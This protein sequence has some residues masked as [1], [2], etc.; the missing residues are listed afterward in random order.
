MSRHGI[1]IG[2]IRLHSPVSAA[3]ASSRNEQNVGVERLGKYNG[4]DKQKWQNRQD[5]IFLDDLVATLEAHRDHNR[6][7]VIHKFEQNVD[8]AL[9][10]FK[11]LSLDGASS[12][13]AET[14]YERGGDETDTNGRSST[15]AAGP[16]P[17]EVSVRAYRRRQ[18]PRPL[19]WPANSVQYVEEGSKTRNTGFI[20]SLD[21]LEY[22]GAV[23]PIK[24]SWKWSGANPTMINTPWAPYMEDSTGD[25]YERSITVESRQELWLTRSRLS[26]EI[27]AFEAYMR[28]SPAEEAAAKLVHSDVTL[29][30]RKH[31][32]P[33]SL[34]L[35]GSRST[36]LAAPT[37][38]FDYRVEID[39]P[40]QASR[41]DSQGLTPKAAKRTTKSPLKRIL[42]GLQESKDIV[43]TEL[44]HVPVATVKCRHRAT[45]L[46]IQFRA[47]SP[48]K[49]S[50]Q[51]TAAY[52]SEFPSLRPLYI[53][54][55]H[56]LEIRDLTSVFL[57]GL[58][59]YTILMMIV[60][61]LKHSS[62]KFPPNDLGGQLLHI[63]DFYGNAD[64]Y[65]NGFSA[66]PPRT[67]KKIR[68]NKRT[69][70]E[71]EALYSDLQLQ[72]VEHLIENSNPRKPYLLCLQDPAHA[73]ND[74]GKH[75][76]AIK[77][78]Q[79][80]FKKMHISL[81]VAL[82]LAQST[83]KYEDW[84]FL[85]PMVRADYSLFEIDRRNIERCNKPDVKLTRKDATED[86][87]SALLERRLKIY[88]SEMDEDDLPFTP[89][90]SDLEP[91]LITKYKVEGWYPYEFRIKPHVETK[92]DRGQTNLKAT[93]RRE[94]REKKKR[95]GGAGAEKDDAAAKK[96]D[97]PG[98]EK[99][100]DAETEGTLLSNR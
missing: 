2:H 50:Q 22:T 30:L 39:S 49:A 40:E 55:R 66:D 97:A 29:I 42:R 71:R 77:H 24:K 96:E 31:L 10:P 100:N 65:E 16:S 14:T 57:G 84:S 76:Y 35:L 7:S 1:S 5:L 52:L 41:K 11:R 3:T 99:T 59:P 53:L 63:L 54:I 9:L 88:K 56:F 23:V 94:K 47:M 98:S 4:Q 51:Y 69:P 21:P 58:S 90:C 20:R 70:K 34:T 45:G 87:I 78:V 61:A 75:S 33:K 85:T 83:Q 15:S 91:G 8:E 44:V 6:A 18:G 25:N 36:G 17:S 60:A 67:F 89:A 43:A 95:K 38:D 68:E 81:K 86:T 46:D 19:Q 93:I 62:G 12:E 27:R 37:S 92:W 82:S 26:N 80:T 73:Y 72:G 48:S 13:D 79:N 64:L 32:L 28:L 74:L